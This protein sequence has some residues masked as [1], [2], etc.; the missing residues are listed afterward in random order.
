M[1]GGKHWSALS[2]QNES[3]SHYTK[4]FCPF[5]Q[6]FCS[7]VVNGASLHPDYATPKEIM[8]KM[9]TEGHLND[10]LRILLE[11]KN[12]ARQSPYPTLIIEVKG[13]P[14]GD[15]CEENTMIAARVGLVGALDDSVK[16]LESIFAMSAAM[17][18]CENKSGDLFYNAIGQVSS[19]TIE[20]VIYTTNELK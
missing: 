5:S 18:N 16:K 2:L 7:I 4:C 8:D 12:N 17:H 3:I 6:P 15:D 13:D 10:E 14:K 11:R 19:H 20:I 1:N 9:E